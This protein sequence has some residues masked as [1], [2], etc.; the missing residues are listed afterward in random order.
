MIIFSV[1]PQSREWLKHEKCLS[2][3]QVCVMD[4]KVL[5]SDSHLQVAPLISPLPFFFF[6]T[7]RESLRAW[8][9]NRWS[10]CHRS[11]HF[12]M[13]S[14]RI[15]MLER[16]VILV[17]VPTLWSLICFW[18]FLCVSF[19]V[20]VIC[21]MALC[22]I[23][24]RERWSSKP[25]DV[26]LSCWSARH[27]VPHRQANAGLSVEALQMYRC[28]FS[29]LKSFCS[30]LFDVFIYSFPTFA[31]LILVCLTVI[32]CFSQRAVFQGLSQEALSACI[33]SL[34]KA[35]DIILKN[36]VGTHI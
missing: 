12:L 15:L 27:V 16:T 17:C 32:W 31:F 21:L 4:F 19:R 29:S 8:K 5:A 24:Y 34:L 22:L 7:I 11:P 6:I 10:R 2:N 9:K 3:F 26:D 20:I 28:R 18:G 33:Q 1:I 25:P 30:E 13:F 36:K 35:S 14:S 23:I